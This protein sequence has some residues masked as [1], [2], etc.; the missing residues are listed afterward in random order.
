LVVGQPLLFEALQ[1]IIKVA[2]A[3]NKKRS[4]VVFF[5]LKGWVK[6][7]VSVLYYFKDTYLLS[8]KA[9]RKI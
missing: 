1:E 4:A 3:N 6:R 9:F 7:F 5:I 2:P 8:N